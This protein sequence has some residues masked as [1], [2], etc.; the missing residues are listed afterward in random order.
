VKGLL[1]CFL[2]LTLNPDSGQTQ[3]RRPAPVAIV[4]TA[5][6][7]PGTMTSGQ[8][9]HRGCIALSRS[10]AK[11]LGLYRGP[12]QYDYQFGAVVELNGAGPYDGEYV[13]MDLMPQRWRHYRV[14]IWMPTAQQCRA[15]GIKKC[16]LK[17]RSR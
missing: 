4:A 15:F 5:Y 11:D 8:R 9:T 13:F 10:L 17:V 14:D 1:L 2:L 12:G 6:C 3:P 7:L 16:Q